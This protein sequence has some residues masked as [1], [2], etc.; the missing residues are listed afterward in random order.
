MRHLKHWLLLLVSIIATPVWA[1]TVYSLAVVPQFTTIDIGLR[2]TPLLER[3]KK[4]T[5][6]TLQIRSTQDIPAF[7][8]EFMTGIPDFVYLNPYHMVMAKKAQGYQ[9]LIRSN[10]ALSGILVVR[11]DTNIHQL[12]DLKGATLAFPAPN[13]F[14]ASLYMRAL[15]KEEEHLDFTPNYVSTHQ[16]VYRHVLYGDALAGGGVA[17]T[18][19]REPAGIRD[20]LRI[21]YRT[22]N[23]APHPL[24]AHPRVSKQIVERVTQA[25]QALAADDEGIKMLMRV[26]LEGVV[27]ADYARDY[28]PL[29]KL[30]L[31]HYV[32][33]E[34]K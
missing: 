23:A 1:E 17:A 27:P 9:P 31:E 29:E 2:W 5:G 22:P 30:G 14:G 4:E 15:L 19:E 7:E 12:S 24:A 34:K 28:A 8:A 18:L 16:N 10:R 32:V 33:M 13:A 6:I 26:G 25:F 21:L 11:K 20:Q 3:I